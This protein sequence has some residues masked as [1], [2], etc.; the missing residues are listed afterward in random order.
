[1]A[2]RT[3]HDHPA[4][5]AAGAHLALLKSQ[6]T[7]AKRDYSAT[8]AK[9][10]P[11]QDAE[12]AL[13][14]G[15]EVGRITV[16]PGNDARSQAHLRMIALTGAIAKQEKIVARELHAARKW[17]VESDKLTEAHGKLL[18]SVAEAATRF[19]EAATQLDEFY[20]SLETAGVGGSAL[21]HYGF[22][23][24]NIGRASD[25]KSRLSGWF[26]EVWKRHPEVN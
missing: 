23:A 26:A 10:D 13:L 4:S 5:A 14:A 15:K 16:D 7:Q 3:V 24:F 12:A 11:I 1:M 22:G 8:T 9:V 6:L 20:A 21:G 18:Q 25:P 17:L 2:N 19:G